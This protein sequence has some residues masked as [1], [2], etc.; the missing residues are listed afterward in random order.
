M[1]TLTVQFP[2]TSILFLSQTIQ[3]SNKTEDAELLI[4]GKTNR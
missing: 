4:G 1:K 2:E 3:S